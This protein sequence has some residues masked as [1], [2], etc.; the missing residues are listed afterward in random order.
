[1]SHRWHHHRQYRVE[2]MLESLRM[3]PLLEQVFHRHRQPPPPPLLFVVPVCAASSGFKLFRTSLPLSFLFSFRA[4]FNLLSS[5]P[6]L[7]LLTI[8]THPQHVLPC[9]CLAFTHSLS[10]FLHPRFHQHHCK[11]IR[12]LRHQSA[13][14]RRS[15]S[16][17]C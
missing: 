9:V 5:A 10:C 17:V 1:M 4:D 15:K 6:S 8:P 14:S 13:F 7:S 3:R 11:R 2:M 12:I 16:S